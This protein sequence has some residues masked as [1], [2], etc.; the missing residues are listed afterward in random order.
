MTGHHRSTF[1]YMRNQNIGVQVHYTPVHL[2][3][4]YRRLGFTHGDFPE[5]EK[6]ATNALSIPLYPG[7]TEE[8]QNRVCEALKIIL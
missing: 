7:L 8:E 2:Q 4:Y 3:P 1:E 6:Y 5:A